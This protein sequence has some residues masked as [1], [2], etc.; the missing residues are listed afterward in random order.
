MVSAAPNQNLTAGPFPPHCVRGKAGSALYGPVHSALVGYVGDK[1]VAI[2][3]LDT[4]T[5]SFGV[6]PY[7]KASWGMY[8]DAGLLNTSTARERV[9][10]A[11]MRSMLTW[12]KH[13]A[14]STGASS[15]TYPFPEYVKRS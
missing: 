8:R 7:S 3:G 13:M 10:A 6:M 11:L 4:S 12:E 15:Y 2:K 14:A 1:H 5:D 9:P